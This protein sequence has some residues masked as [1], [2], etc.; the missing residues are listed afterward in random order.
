M[1]LLFVSTKRKPRKSTRLSGGGDIVVLGEVGYERIVLW[2]NISKTTGRTPTT[3][4]VSI[5]ICSYRYPQILTSPNHVGNMISVFSIMKFMNTD[6]LS[7]SEKPVAGIWCSSNTVIDQ[8]HIPA[9]SLGRHSLWWCYLRVEM[10]ALSYTPVLPAPPTC[11][12]VSRR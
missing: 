12:T 6:S 8:Q 5:W 1:G 11:T 7:C 9:P 2:K 4:W 3:M 10:H